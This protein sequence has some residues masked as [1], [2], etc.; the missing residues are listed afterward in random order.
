[1]TLQRYGNTDYQEE[2]LAKIER[3]A[4]ALKFNL[5]YG[6]SIGKEPQ[7]VVLDHY[8]QDGIIHVSS[9]D[10]YGISFDGESNVSLLQLK[11]LMK[12]KLKEEGK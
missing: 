5:K 8:Y 9:S 2:Q 7:S 11:E 4:K 10:K 1:M 3:L 6:T 12:N